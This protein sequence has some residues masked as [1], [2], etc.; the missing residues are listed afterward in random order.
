M[1]LR[2]AD[3][4][5]HRYDPA[6]DDLAQIGRVSAAAVWSSSENLGLLSEPQG[7]ALLLVSPTDQWELEAPGPVAWAAPVGPGVAVVSVETSGGAELLLLRF[8]EPEPAVGI[9][10]EVSAPALVTAWGGSLVASGRGS[11]HFV[12]LPD[13][14]I[15][16]ETRLEGPVVALATSPSAHQIYAAT[17]EG[18][19]LFA[20]SRYSGSTRGIG[21]FPAGIREIRPSIMGGSLVVFDGSVPWVTGTDGGRPRPI[22]SDWRP[23]LPLGL[24][25]GRVLAARSGGVWLEQPGSAETATQLSDSDGDW[26]LTISWVPARPATV[27]VA[28]V[29]PPAIGADETAESAELPGLPI[30]RPDVQT[31]VRVRPGFYAIVSSSQSPDGIM[32]LVESLE[33]AD[34]PGALQ[35][36]RDESNELWYRA[37]VGPYETREGAEEVA[38]RL[39]RDRGLQVWISEIGPDGPIRDGGDG[40]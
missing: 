16:N 40:R 15:G 4:A 6:R 34:Y 8:G 38:V 36:Y 28:E 29:E 35:R 11:L 25:G 19:E 23:D 30:E 21:D 14:T 17:G 10:T 32:A 3:G 26:W 37:L 7:T 5:I 24:P 33:R 27:A 13:L 12:S 31:E 39:R 9:P 1:I 22:D 18:T 2:T 20:V